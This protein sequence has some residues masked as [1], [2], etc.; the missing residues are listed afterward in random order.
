M[1][2]LL[3]EQL[4]AAG[5]ATEVAIETAHVASVIPLVLAGAGVAILPEGMAASCR[6]GRAGGAAGSA[7]AGSVSLVWRRDRLGAVAEHF[8]M[9]ASESRSDRDA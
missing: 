8:V 2:T 6:Q 1:R 5:T 9:V 4:E 7:D 3:D